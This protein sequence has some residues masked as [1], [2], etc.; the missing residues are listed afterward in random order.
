MIAYLMLAGLAALP[1]NVA[2]WNWSAQLAPALPSG[3][4]V[5]VELTPEMTAHSQADL[6]DI[7]VLN[8]LDV[9][10]PYVF[11]DVRFQDVEKLEWREPLLINRVY[12][13]KFSSQITLDFREQ[14]LK[15][16]LKVELSGTNFRRRVIVEASSDNQKWQRIG[17][18]YYLFKIPAPEKDFIVDAINLPENDY[19]Y[20]RL[21]VFHMDEDPERVEFKT[22]RSALGETLPAHAPQLVSDVAV[23]DRY[24][25]P[26]L[27]YSEYDIDTQFVNLPLEKLDVQ[28]KDEYFY[29]PYE[30]YGRNTL[31][32]KVAVRKENGAGHVVRETPWRRLTTGVFYRIKGPDKTAE[33]L[34]TGQLHASCRYL[35]LRMI[36]RDNPPVGLETVKVYRRPVFI[37]FDW[38]PETS[39]KLIGGNEKAARP[40]FTLAQAVK[41]LR[42]MDLPAAQVGS[43]TLREAPPKVEPWT[44][45]YQTLIWAA[46]FTAVSL[47][48]VMVVV[49]MPKVKQ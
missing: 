13:E 18:D 40:E 10:V 5:R 21:T 38:K 4:F 39:Y 2:E 37:A 26:K 16:L 45:R 49:N 44:E 47:M 11:Q 27:P 9:M 43:L 23:S 32:E 24:R 34:C 7:R 35:Q 15:S 25:E 46:L 1:V 29:I 30:L 42:N 31:S 3:G 19:Q 28:I 8:D 17:D 22:V 33:E 48:V 20:L 41:E 36:E 14:V 12:D 6:S